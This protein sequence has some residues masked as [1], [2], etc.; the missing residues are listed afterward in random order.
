MYLSLL[1]FGI[2]ASV[3][4][5]AMIA[6]GIPI[7]QFGLGNTLILAGTT[8]FVGGLILIGLSEAVKQLRRIAEGGSWPGAKPARTADLFNAEASGRTG[9][10]RIPFPP[11]P[12][13]EPGREPEPF[14][15][16]LTTAPS[17]D[18]TEE[19]FDRPPPAFMRRE[20][21]VLPLQ[22]EPRFS[23]K[24]EREA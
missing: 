12:S 4:G 13:L 7:N 21:T 5:A 11:K 18:T 24:P 20:E 23:M 1:V 9:A 17:L 2:F 8:A 3:A 14:E 15:P 10:G 19:Q 22:P 6:F 16:R